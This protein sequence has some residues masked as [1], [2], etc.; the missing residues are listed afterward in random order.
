MKYAFWAIFTI[1][2]LP[3]LASAEFIGKDPALKYQNGGIVEVLL[4][5]GHDNYNSGA[6]FRGQREADMNLI[7]AEKLA[8]ELSSDPNVFVTVSRDTNGYYPPLAKY[9]EENRE[10]IFEFIDDSKK[11]TSKFLEK[12]DIEVPV[13]VTHNN[14][15]SEVAF[16]LY[17]INH[18][19]AEES[20][21]MVIHIHFNDDTSHWGN[22][23]GGYGGFT[24]YVPE[25]NLLN[26]DK[27]IPLAQEIGREMRKTFFAS[28]LPIE[29]DRADEFGL[30]PDFKLIALGSNRTLET[31]SVLVEY[32]YI[33]EPHVSP[34]FLGLS[35]D[36]MAR[37]TA[38]GVFNVLSGVGE[39]KNLYHVWK[40][41]LSL[42]TKTDIDTLALQF[43]LKELGFYPPKNHDREN[44]PFTGIY[45]PCTQKA[46]KEFQRA[47]G[48]EADGFAGPKTLGVMNG[49]F[50]F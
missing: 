14:A 38:K 39:W 50:G 12:N 29:R 27:S 18:W 24:I 9:L 20:F 15:P 34:E 47:S 45:G 10:E 41:P 46:V 40:K 22:N 7:L 37:A 49:V 3:A 44:C 25:E 19:V 17:G 30:V 11:E 36:T 32:S 23:M 5:P 31:P 42:G 1:L 48:L 13:G 26:S 43:G 21:D 4:V 8:R 28:N 35:T 2:V 16:T 33:Y 6:V